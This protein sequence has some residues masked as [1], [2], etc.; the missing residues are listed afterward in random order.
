MKY[1]SKAVRL[2]DVIVQDIWSGNYDRGKYLPG[3]DALAENYQVSRTTIRRVLDILNKEGVLIKEPNRGTLI[4]PDLKQQTAKP[5]TTGKTVTIGAVWAGFPDAMTIGI[6]D[7]IKAFATEQKVGFQLF[8]SSEGH[9]KVL[10]Y[11]HHIDELGVAGVILLPY[12]FP[13]YADALRRLKQRHF[14]MVCVDRPV[15]GVE[16]SCIEVD[17]AGGV[18]R[19]V[20]KMLVAFR[21]PV[22]YLG[23]Q[24][25][26]RTQLLRYQ[27]Y[28]HA[29][30]DSG[31]EQEIQRCTHF[32]PP[33]DN[34]PE[35]WPVEKKL[36]PPYI[37]A[38][39]ILRNATTPIS[40]M[41]M[42]DYAARSVYRAAEELKLRVGR[43]IMLFGFDDLPL[44][45]C[46]ECP[47]SSV[48]QPRREIGFEA[49]KLLCEEID[50]KL[51]QPVTKVLPVELMERNSSRNCLER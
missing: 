22:H 39:D 24:P 27:G 42:N 17:N 34:D 25:G 43:D 44:A 19:A 1:N 45:S 4:N 15:E 12:N 40:I 30:N 3:E 26:N 8:Q 50:G 28:L 41:A 48:R 16:L 11:L 6:A 14:P 20:V 5:A 23:A 51:S 7:G 49:A 2:A 47:L 21:R 18:Y 38:L 36:E 13:G 46:L 33:T 35:F 9:A 29:M 10:D 37:V 31:F 32:Y